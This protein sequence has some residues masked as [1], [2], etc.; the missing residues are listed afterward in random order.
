MARFKLLPAFVV[1][2]GKKRWRFYKWGR[3][4]YRKD[5]GRWNQLWWQW[6]N[7]KIRTKQKLCP[8]EQEAMLAA[9]NSWLARVILAEG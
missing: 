1:V 2:Y 9:Y 4:E 5:G 8:E 6:D 3:C 7:G